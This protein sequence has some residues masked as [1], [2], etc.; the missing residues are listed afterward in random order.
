[1]SQYRYIILKKDSYHFD[2]FSI[3]TLRKQ[4]IFKIKEWRNSQID[5]LRQKV[6]LTNSDQE[7]YYYQVVVPTFSQIQPKIVL[8]S[9]LK[10][11]QCIGYGGLTNI[12]WEAKRF[13]LSFL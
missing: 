5:V 4:D 3:E 13:E 6:H 10:E 11:G 1:M 12:D 2:D 8:F 9:F 7:N